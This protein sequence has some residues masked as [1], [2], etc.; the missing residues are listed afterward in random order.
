MKKQILLY[1]FSL[2]SAV[3]FAQNASDKVSFGLQAGYANYGMQGDAVSNL[4]S[5]IDYADGMVTTKNR[6]GFY[7]GVNASIPLGS[8][9]SL[10]PAVQYT[11]KGYEL[12]GELNI[13]GL[14]FLGA[15]AKAQLQNDYIDIP[16]L[17][18]ADLGGFNVFA[19]PQVSYLASSKLRTTAGVLGI[20]LLDKKLD[21]SNQFNKWDA[22][23]T[24][25]LGYS[26]S[27]FNINASYDYGLSK[28]DANKSVKSYNRGFKLGVGIGF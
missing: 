22:G 16:V 11:Q 6:N 10:V 26:F 24:A 5:L 19:G 25:G 2:L 15:N 7:A 9:V 20:N 13:K 12:N 27:N 4:K 23:V 17:L 14:E 18:K 28:V 1:F 3:G 8:G 21:A